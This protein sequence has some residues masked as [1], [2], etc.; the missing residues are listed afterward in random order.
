ME[1]VL[2]H[3]FQAELLK[4][5]AAGIRIN[6]RLGKDVG[7]S[8]GWNSA[9]GG[10]ATRFVSAG[11]GSVQPGAVKSLPGVGKR[12]TLP[13]RSPPVTAETNNQVALR[14]GLSNIET[15]TR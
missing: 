1:D 14:R 2:L 13:V 3:S 10:L 9:K 12:T 4:I 11:V 8:W 6:E 5:A 15:P 7:R